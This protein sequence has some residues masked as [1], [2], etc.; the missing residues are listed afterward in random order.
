MPTAN[1]TDTPALAAN[2]TMKVAIVHDWLVIYGGAE[3]VLEHIIDLYPQADLFSLIDFVSEDQRH[4][5]RGKKPTTSFLQ[6]IPGAR[7]H[8]R[9]LLPL[10]PLAIEQLDLSGYD[11]IISSHYSVAKGVLTGPNQTH[12]CYCHSPRLLRSELAN[13]KQKIQ[14]ATSEPQALDPK[15]GSNGAFV[16]LSKAPDALMA[17]SQRKRD[18]EYWENIVTIL[19]QYTELGKMDETRDFSLFQVLD[20]AISPQTKSRPRI[21]VNVILSGAGSTM[22]TVMFIWARAYIRQR[23]MASTRFAEQLQILKDE[24]LKNPWKRTGQDR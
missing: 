24:L 12:V 6:K 14:E 18:V 11:L 16:P 4:F 20:I 23:R 13:L 15:A 1:T 21:K 9:K 17:H 22:L 2:R 7:Q 19:G 3:R 10:M 5:L 8:Y